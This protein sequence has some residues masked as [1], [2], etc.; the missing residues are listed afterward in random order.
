M[1]LQVPH[2]YHSLNNDSAP[3]N[4]TVGTGS[5]TNCY[6]KVTTN[7]NTVKDLILKRFKQV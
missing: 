4:Q 5:S 3:W 2:N 7:N 6:F 1:N